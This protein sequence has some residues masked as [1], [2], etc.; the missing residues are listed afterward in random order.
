MTSLRPRDELLATNS[1][2][3]QGITFFTIVATDKLPSLCSN[4]PL[5][6]GQAILIKFCGPQKKKKT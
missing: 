1:C 2:W 3:R 4:L 5:T 6:F